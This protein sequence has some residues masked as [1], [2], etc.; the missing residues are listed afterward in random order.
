[1][2]EKVRVRNPVAESA[3]YHVAPAARLSTLN[4]KRIAL[5]WNLK[6]GGEV[7]LTRAAEML[8]ARYPGLTFDLH[9]GEKGFAVRTVTMSQADAIASQYDAVIGASSD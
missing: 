9:S 1:M 6:G 4:N 8:A 7:A 5:F 2:A 3:Q